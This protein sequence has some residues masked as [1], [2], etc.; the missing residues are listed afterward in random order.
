ME[1]SIGGIFIDNRID[2]RKDS[3]FLI[4]IMKANV[5][6]RMVF[7]F[8]HFLEENACTVR[9]YAEVIVSLCENVLS[10]PQEE[11]SQQ[12]GIDRDISKLI[13]A[14]YDETANTGSTIDK[15]IAER[16]LE[17]WDVMFERQIGQVRELSRELM[18]R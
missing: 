1:F 16:C 9:D 10:M 12:W 6:R 2:L 17:L 4:E 14:L 15:K 13:I 5:S 7:Q 18:E 3:Q 8:V 11:L